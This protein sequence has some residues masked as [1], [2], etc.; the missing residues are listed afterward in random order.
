MSIVWA[1]QIMGIC[2]VPDFRIRSHLSA[3]CNFESFAA[4]YPLQTIETAQLAYWLDREITRY[5]EN[6]LF[7]LGGQQQ[8]KKKSNYLATKRKT[9][10]SA[11]MALFDKQCY[12]RNNFF[13]KEK[14]HRRSTYLGHRSER[15]RYVSR[16]HCD[17]KCCGKYNT[18]EKWRRGKYEKEEGGG[19]RERKRRE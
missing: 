8:Q 3:E 9:A 5:W 2:C 7:W 16:K 6:R 11:D 14:L 19:K 10:Q 13:F 18:K 1:R 4:D 12:S 15:R 17:W